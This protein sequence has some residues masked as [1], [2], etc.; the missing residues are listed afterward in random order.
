MI[1]SFFA[2]KK[3]AAFYD[4][5]GY[6]AEGKKNTFYNSF[7]YRRIVLEYGNSSGQDLIAQALGVNPGEWTFNYNDMPLEMK[8]STSVIAGFQLNYAATKKDAVLVNVNAVKLTSNGNFTMVVTTPPIGPQPPG[9]Q[10]IRTFGISGGEQRLMIQA[11]YR[12]I[13]VD[14]EVF[15]CFVEIGPS[16]NMTKYLRNQIAINNLHIDLAYYYSQNYFP[17]YHARYLHGT[18]LGIFAGFG[19]NIAA[20]SNWTL[21]LLYSPSYEKINIGEDPKL[22]LQHSAGIRAF[23]T[24]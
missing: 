20:N 3:T 19:V 18:G 23:Y 22:S 16:L 10:D 14:D 17:T 13:L 4:G 9:Y 8:Y 7:M 12:R 5:Y 6:D 24:L 21:Q 15:N 2:N 1:G 11:G